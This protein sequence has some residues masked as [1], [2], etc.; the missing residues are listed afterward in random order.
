MTLECALLVETIS[1]KYD[2]LIRKTD[3][4]ERGAELGECIYFGALGR[5]KDVQE[6]LTK[7]DDTKHLKR[8]IKPFLIQWGMMGRAIGRKSLDWV[9]LGARLRNLEPEFKELRKRRLL[10]IDFGDANIS[11]AIRKIYRELDSIKYIGSGTTISKILHLLNPQ[12]F[13]MWDADIRKTYRKANDCIRETPEG[14]LEFL[15]EIQKEVIIM[16]EDRRKEVR[17]GLD[18]I[19][20][21]I[22]H[23][24][25]GKTI[26]KIVDEY[27]YTKA[28]PIVWGS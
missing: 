14:Y 24:Y 19:E 1:M 7:L 22:S 28:H 26:S 2:D 25:K 27:N 21:E 20:Q 9:R 6:D 11:A 17:K 23:N 5:L 12:I 15:K 8:V 13:V 3:E 10:T 16:L 18:E 4:Y